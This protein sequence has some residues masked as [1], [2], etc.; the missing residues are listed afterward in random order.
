MVYLVSAKALARGTKRKG[1]FEH[2]SSSSSSSS[3]T[4]DESSTASKND[5]NKA[6]VNTNDTSI[7]QKST[8]LK[9]KREEFINGELFKED[10]SKLYSLIGEEFDKLENRSQNGG[11]KKISNY[12]IAKSSQIPTILPPK[13]EILTKSLSLFC[14]HW[15]VPNNLEIIVDIR[16]SDMYTVPLKDVVLKTDRQYILELSQQKATFDNQDGIVHKQKFYATF[17]NTISRPRNKFLRELLVKFYKRYFNE[18]STKILKT[19]IGSN[20]KTMKSIIIYD[21]KTNAVPKILTDSTI[22]SAVCFSN[23]PNKPILYIDYVATN[24]QYVRGSFAPMIMNTAQHCGILYFQ[25]QNI[26]TNP[27][28]TFLNCIKP[29]SGVYM[30][31]GFTLC[32]LEEM[33]NPENPFHCVY[34]HFECKEWH[35]IGRPDSEQSLVIMCCNEIIPRWTNLLNYDLDTVETFAFKDNFSEKDPEIYKEVQLAQGTEYA[36][37]TIFAKELK[38]IVK[39]VQNRVYTEGDI[40]EYQSSEG[41]PKYVLNIMQTKRIFIDIGD[42]F[43]DQFDS[44][45]DQT[46]LYLERPTLLTKE[47]LKELSIRII[48]DSRCYTVEDSNSFGMW[49]QMKCRKCK[50]SCFLRKKH[51]IKFDK[52]LIQAIYS[53]WTTHVFGLKEN[54]SDQWNKFNPCWNHCKSRIKNYFNTLKHAIIQDSTKK[55]ST[56]NT[57][58]SYLV[59]CTH[60]QVIAKML[61]EHHKNMVHAWFAV[62]VDIREHLKQDR[63]TT[64]LSVQERSKKLIEDIGV[65]KSLVRPSKAPRMQTK[66]DIVNRHLAEKKWNEEYYNDLTIQQRLRRIGFVDPTKTTFDKMMPDSQAYVKYHKSDEYKKKRKKDPTVDEEKLTHFIGITDS[67]GGPTRNNVGNDHVI[68]EGYFQPRD[69]FGHIIGPPR[70]SAAT[71]RRCKNNPNRLHQLNTNDRKAINKHAASLLRAGEIQKVRLLEIDEKKPYKIETLLYDG[72]RF[73][74]K[75]RFEGVDKEGRI[76]FLSDDWL[77]LNFSQEQK[78]LDHIMSSPYTGLFVNVPPGRRNT[79]SIKFPFSKKHQGPPIF[80][81][82]MNE[83]SCLYC[84][85]ASAFHILKEP[86]VAQKI[87]AVYHEKSKEKDFFPD[88][89]QILQ[90]F[91]NKHRE[92]FEMAIKVVLKKRNYVTIEA[93]LEDDVDQIILLVLGNRHAIALIKNYIIDP[94]FS[95]ALPRTET[96]L[97]LSAEVETKGTTTKIIK[98][99]YSFSTVHK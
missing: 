79:N 54:P 36:I 92:K 42:I 25:Q 38:S 30:N 59:Q 77:K 85:I 24:E 13:K 26:D 94:A 68:D 4:S 23:E 63:T 83:S 34:I 93:L 32:N 1:N 71:I 20:S 86:Q 28:V 66:Q 78:F 15:I 60:I 46:N 99:A 70:I 53:R 21:R 14:S 47:M 16:S 29:L 3:D 76:H 87:M 6:D 90:I 57:T 96:S 44:Y 82:Q 10:K 65:T 40:S 51:G 5:L 33:R 52:F 81:R 17:C 22:V 98:K 61:F 80:Y 62:G 69:K 43:N 35:I 7:F 18:E 97:R 39:S 55:S 74:S 48:P 27:M 75:I 89:L 67:Q 19:D 84:S 9:K 56:Y 2:S 31:Y 8:C 37:K 49:L 73:E 11:K 41:V 95:H 12:D 58:K 72:K 64:F 50:Q 91:R 45:K 88:H